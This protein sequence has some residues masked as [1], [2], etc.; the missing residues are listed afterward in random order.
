MVRF[1]QQ[2]AVGHCSATQE[3]HQPP[4]L[5]ISHLSIQLTSMDVVCAVSLP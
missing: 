2:L 1:R 5:L 3:H 4:F